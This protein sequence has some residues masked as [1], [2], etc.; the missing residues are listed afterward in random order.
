MSAAQP[1]ERSPSAG[2]MSACWRG[3][4][5]AWRGAPTTS[6]RLGGRALV[7]PTDV[8]DAGQVEAAAAAVERAFGPIDVWVNNAMVSVFSPIKQMEPEEY[9]RVTEVTYL[10]TVY[11]TLAALRRMLPRDRG[12]DRPGRLG[13]GLPRHP[14]PVGLLRRQARHPGLLRLAALRAD[15]RQEPCPADDGPDAGPEHD[16]VRLGQEPPA[17]E[18]ATGSADLPAGGRRR[19]DRLGRAPQPAL[20]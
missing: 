1:R 2:P 7:V 3:A 5:R 6:R 18:G 17:A 13:A 4:A 12:R 10:G 19:G 8:A 15:P 11:G 16:A 20:A 9:R 14:A